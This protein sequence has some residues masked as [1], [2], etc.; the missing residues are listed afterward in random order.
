MKAAGSFRLGL[1]VIFTAALAVVLSAAPIQ[2]VVVVSMDGARPDTVLWANTPNVREIASKGA[3]TWWAQTIMPSITLISHSSML[4]G[5]QPAKHGITWNDHQPA[6][7]FVKT[8]TCFEIAKKAGMG[9]AM[10]VGK[11]KLHHIAK[12]D[13]VDQFEEIKGGAIPIAT[14]AVEILQNTAPAILFVHFPDPDAAGHPNGWGSAPF[15]AAVEN[16]DKGL[17]LLL[18]AIRDPKLEG[19]TILIVTA[20]HG[21]HK[22]GHGSADPRDTTIPWICYSPNPNLIIAGQIDGRVSTCDT[23][24]TA[25][26]A[27]GLT[28]DSA[29]DGK[30]VPIFPASSNASQPAAK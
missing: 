19:N 11:I 8:S 18:T 21:G 30:V 25:V 2:H 27:L 15:L 4:T 16:C 22:K 29:W 13:T 23:A 20:D 6:K 17:G 26:A 12:P 9:T 5:S 1:F 10:V 28:P 7:G 3:Y 14:K 24:A